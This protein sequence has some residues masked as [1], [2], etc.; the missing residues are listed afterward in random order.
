[1]MSVHRR[2]AGEALAPPPKTAIAGP[3]YFGLTHP[4]ILPAIEA[5]DHARFCAAY[6][7]GREVSAIPAEP[8]PLAVLIAAGLHADSSRRW[9]HTLLQAYDS[10]GMSCL[11][12]N[13]LELVLSTG[14]DNLAVIHL[15]RYTVWT[16]CPHPSMASCRLVISNEDNSDAHQCLV[17]LSDAR[18]LPP[19]EPQCV[20]QAPMRTF[21]QAPGAQLQ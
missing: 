13:L 1:M 20:P 18:S 21:H 4:A 7:A 5:L 15:A 11:R 6:W 3:D 2:D 12:R 8:V 19:D 14:G 17:V 16:Q 9:C 10:A